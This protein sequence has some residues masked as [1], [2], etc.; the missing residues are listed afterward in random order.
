VIENGRVV[1]S[2]RWDDLNARRDGRFRALCE[3]QALG[4]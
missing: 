1:E 4:A 3:A 2:G